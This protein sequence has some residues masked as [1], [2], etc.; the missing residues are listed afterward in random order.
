MNPSVLHFTFESAVK[1]NETGNPIRADI[2]FLRG[3]AVILVVMYH[4]G[5]GIGRGY[6]GVDAFFAISGFL[7]SGILLREIDSGKFS[8]KNFYLR[9][10]RRLLPALICTLFFTTILAIFILSPVQLKDFSDQLLGA[11]TFTSNFVLPGQIGYF[12]G[13]GEDKAFAAYLVFVAGG[14]VLSIVS[15]FCFF[16]SQKVSDSFFCCRSVH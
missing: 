8:F 1:K 5:L 11:L 10:S 9:R 13:G 15:D 6:L 16:D 4:S 12:E 3:V 7:I 14:A 2:Q